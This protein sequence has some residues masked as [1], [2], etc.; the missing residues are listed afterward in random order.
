MNQKSESDSKPNPGW[1]PKGQSGNPGGRPKTTRAPQ[2]SPFEIV[3]E[4][5]LTVSLPGGGTREI[6]SEEALQQQIFQ[7]ALKGERMAQR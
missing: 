5:T 3:T 2:R 1:F 7:K 4:K 6:S